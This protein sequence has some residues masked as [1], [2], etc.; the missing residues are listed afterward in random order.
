MV[1]ESVYCEIWFFNFSKLLIKLKKIK[2]KKNLNK[3][4]KEKLGKKFSFSLMY[5]THKR[6]AFY[7]KSKD[8]GFHEYSLINKRNH[9]DYNILYHF[10]QNM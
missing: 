7:R 6:C 9:Y 2:I 8:V 1:W 10:L 4:E 5:L 3:K